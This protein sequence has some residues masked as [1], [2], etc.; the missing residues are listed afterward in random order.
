MKMKQVL[1]N[2]DRDRMNGM[3]L[4]G[5]GSD[6]KESRGRKRIRIEKIP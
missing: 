3:L 2:W 6:E 4:A 1:R 5:A